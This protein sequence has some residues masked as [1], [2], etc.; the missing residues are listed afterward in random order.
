[1]K[2]SGACMLT[3][4]E[5][6]LR[7]SQRM[8][9]KLA[10]DP[11]IQ[12]GARVAAWGGSGFFLSAASLSGGFQ[13]M[14]LGLVTA[15]T[16]WRALVAA[17]GAAAGFRLFWGSAGLQGAVWAAA[18]CLMALLLG[19]G[20]QAERFPLLMPA[21]T[22]VVTAVTGLAF[23]FFRRGSPLHLFF[24][25]L[26][27]A[28]V[29][30]WFFRW[31][32][33][34]RDSVS[35]WV[36]GGIAVLALADLGPLGYGLAAVFA[37]GGSFPAAAL[38]GLGLDLARVTPV[39]MSVVVC[40]AWFGRLIPFQE[41]WMR[42][43]VP[44]LACLA[45]MGL[46]G[47]WDPKPLPGLVLGGIM[48][49]FLP[50]RP[51]TV[52]RQGELGI[53]QVRLEMTAGILARTQQLLLTVQEPGIDEGALLNRAVNRACGNCPAKETCVER[54]NL[55]RD[56]LENPLAFVCR[57]PW[58]IQGELLRAQE[59]LRDLKADRQR[60]QEYR[61]ALIQQYRFLSVYLQRLSDQLPRRGERLRAY[62]RLEASVRSRGKERS[63]G[64]RCLAF[65]GTGC[66]YYVL[67]CDGMGTGL[68]AAQEGQSTGELLRQMLTAGFPPEHAFRSVN[69]LLALR[70][71]AG[72]VTLDLAE[73]RLDSGRVS[74]YKW[75]AAPSYLH[76]ARGTEK[77][78]TAGPPPGLS[79]EDARETV[80][81]LSLRRGEMLI[82]VSDGAEIGEILRRG[83]VGPMPPGELAQWLLEKSGA[84]GEDDA[85]VA[86]LRLSSRRMST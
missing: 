17:L 29:A 13:P 31:M 5:T 25:R 40:A 49:Y 28:P 9:H 39:P 44:G 85:T 38:A 14:A 53:A 23:L 57:R 59:R 83:N 81:R 80:Y 7:R 18:G 82:L 56:C 12:C 65:S 46:C 48:G 3:T 69:S 51:E 58:E 47:I 86:V 70:G 32:L 21:L 42:Y 55:S 35:E 15:V 79:M 30:A 50:P 74:L 62:Y 26:C 10:L 75:G 54:L 52:H 61:S 36:C 76:G 11:R 4:M 77:I 84:G 2:G 41:K 60:R 6:W 37:V 68:G 71:Q 19:K 72:A 73:I 22:A 27:L 43:G 33:A 63:N 1:M 64:D 8:V 45:V 24:L 78:G 66:R 67:L 20:E 16:G 34:R